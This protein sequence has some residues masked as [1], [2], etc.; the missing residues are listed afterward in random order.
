M[1]SLLIPCNLNIPVDEI[2][3]KPH[4]YVPSSNE[5]QEY[6]KMTKEE[7]LN[8]MDKYDREL[9]TGEIELSEDENELLKNDFE[10]KKE[11]EKNSAKKI[12]MNEDSKS[13]LREI[14]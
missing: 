10:L 11:P 9:I 3:M 14:I 1:P 5:F 7:R 8:R 6:Q 4:L 13:I 2:N 12:Q